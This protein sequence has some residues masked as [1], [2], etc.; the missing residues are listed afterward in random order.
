MVHKRIRIKGARNHELNNICKS[1]A[2]ET[3]NEIN[4]A[5]F[6]I[7][8]KKADL[9]TEFRMNL[10]TFTLQRKTVQQKFVVKAEQNAENIDTNYKKSIF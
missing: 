7:N 9:H 4:M 10:N 2:L 8:Y 5:L 6:I 1:G 3:E